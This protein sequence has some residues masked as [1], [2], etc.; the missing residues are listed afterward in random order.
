[1]RAVG[2]STDELMSACSMNRSR[3]LWTSPDFNPES[4]SFVMCVYDQ[5]TSPSHNPA[6][7]NFLVTLTRYRWSCYSRPDQY[8]HRCS[9]SELRT[10]N[11]ATCVLVVCDA[12]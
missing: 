2:I 1:M 8:P 10:I 7:G 9:A 4:V 11:I 6:A 3:Y 5:S 12:A